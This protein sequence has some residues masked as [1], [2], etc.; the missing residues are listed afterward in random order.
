MWAID[1]EYVDREF[2]SVYFAKTLPTAK[3]GDRR[4]SSP[5]KLTTWVKFMDN[6]AKMCPPKARD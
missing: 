6:A 1:S 2:T 5:R 3:I 4:S